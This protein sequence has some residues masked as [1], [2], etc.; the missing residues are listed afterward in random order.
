MGQS[1]SDDLPA[2]IA[3]MDVILPAAKRSRAPRKAVKFNLAY[4]G[5]WSVI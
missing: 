5:L 2:V 3:E 1:R 4:E